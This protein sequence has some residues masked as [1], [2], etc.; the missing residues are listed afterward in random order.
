LHFQRMLSRVA[1][2]VAAGIGPGTMA[3]DITPGIGAGI[4]MAIMAADIIVPATV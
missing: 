3:A 2:S 1:G 4:A